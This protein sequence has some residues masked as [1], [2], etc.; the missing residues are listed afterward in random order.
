M[1]PENMPPELPFPTEKIHMP[2]LSELYNTPIRTLQRTFQRLR[3]Q[4]ATGKKEGHY[5][6]PV[7]QLIIFT[8]YMPPSKYYKSYLWLE[9]H[10]YINELIEKY[11]LEQY[12]KRS[13]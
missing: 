9:K 10:G 11:G 1:Y 5:Y 7:Q 12:V 4:D 3:M 8:V 13:N 6:T 2:G